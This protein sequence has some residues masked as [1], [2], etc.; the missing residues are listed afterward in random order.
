LIL[1]LPAVCASAAFAQAPA[2]GAP[3]GAALDVEAATAAYLAKIPPDK[4]AKSD[5]YFEGGYWLLLWDFLYVGGVLLL[6]L[7]LGWSAAM[8]DRAE[9]IAGRLGTGLGWSR[10]VLY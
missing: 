5:A 4:K 7:H 3:G 10:T 9:R 8:R 2:T 6:L 1:V